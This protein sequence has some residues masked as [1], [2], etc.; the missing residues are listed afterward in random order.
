[1][2]KGTLLL[3]VL[4]V[5]SITASAAMAEELKSIKLVY[6]NNAPAQAGGN[7]FFEKGMAGQC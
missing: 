3:L 7:I 1:M 2:K 5:F 4:L 6:S